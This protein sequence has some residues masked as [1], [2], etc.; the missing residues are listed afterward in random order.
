MSVLSV[1]V[2]N[3]R[4]IAQRPISI[5]WWMSL[6]FA[7]I[8]FGGFARTYLIPVATAQFKGAAILHVHG[9]LF[10]G[11]TVLLALQTFLVGRRRVDLHRVAGMAGVSL[12]TAMV[13]TA[14]VLVVRGLGYS[15]TIGNEAAARKLAIVPMTQ[16]SMFAAFFA[17]AVVT[18]RRPD[19]HK[20]LMILATTSLL[21]APVARIFLAVLAPSGPGLPNF[22][23]VT[24]SSVALLGATLAA[25]IVDVLVVAIA[26]RD[27]RSNRRLHRAY[28]IGGICM[29]LVHGL[30]IPFAGSGLWHSITG[31]LLAFAA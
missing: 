24:D 4:Q 28:L 12:A 29:V 13:F 17:A 23:A 26:I 31:A 27:W 16:I 30:R 19:T 20:R 3:P 6:A 22:G 18:I 21:T 5:Y 2:E 7:L 8:A 25:G 11:W 14:I 1:P 15:A 9:V 10:L